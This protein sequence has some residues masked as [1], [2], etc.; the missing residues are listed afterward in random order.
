MTLKILLVEDNPVDADFL[1]ELLEDSPVTFQ[2]TPVERLKT[3]H[4]ALTQD[5]FDTALLDLSLPDSQ[6][7]ETVAQLR[8]FAPTLPIVVLTGLDDEQMAL[9]AVSNGAQD[10]LVKG[11]ITTE[12][13]VRVIRYAI[14]RGRI[15]KQLQDSEQQTLKALEKERALNQLK[16]Q[17]VSMVS[18]EFRNP[19]M[20][21]QGCAIALQNPRRQLTESNQTRYLDLIQGSINDMLQLLDEVLLLGRAETH[22]LKYDPK[23]LDLTDF[24]QDLVE[25]V[26]LGTFCHKLLFTSQIHHGLAYMDA[27]LLRHILTNLLTNAIK[28]SPENATIQFRLSLDAEIAVFEIQDQGIGIPVADQAHL[29]E[30]FHRARNVGQ[31]QGTGLGLAIVKHCVDLHQGE[32]HLNSEE[33][34]GTL[35]KVTLPT[36][37]L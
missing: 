16:S 37:Q 29:F 10:Y 28:Y 1:A 2:I 36:R 35:V 15:L 32:I 17:F 18:H 9:K 4:D 19:M 33:G 11:S 8:Q 13:L 27:T 7:L 26:K 25:T 12:I 14:E 30:T 24:C 23:D 22:G 34:V 20:V 6:G 21:I 5:S 3:A 31:V